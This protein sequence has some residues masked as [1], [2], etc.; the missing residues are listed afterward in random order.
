V[1]FE[2]VPKPEAERIAGA[3]E[4]DVDSDVRWRCGI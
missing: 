2:V 1:G 3:L 4:H